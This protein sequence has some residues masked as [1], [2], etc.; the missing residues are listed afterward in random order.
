RLRKLVSAAFTPRVIERLKP[1]IQQLVDQYLDAAVERGELEIVA[2]L[3]YPLPV[4]II[5]EL[6]GVPSEDHTMFRSWSKELA[7]S[8]DPE[9]TVPPDVLARRVTILHEFG[10]YFLGL[11]AARRQHPA[12]DLLSALVTVE[13]RGDV[14]TEDELLAT[15]TLLL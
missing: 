2:D 12:D 4:V 5:S 7:A 6:L 15:L 13:D 1:R 11:I 8:L 14:L 3:A 10:E 9:L